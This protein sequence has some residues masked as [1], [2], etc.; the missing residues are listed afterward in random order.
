MNDPQE[1]LVS[2]HLAGLA[3]IDLWLDRVEQMAGLPKSIKDTCASIR[4]YVAHCRRAVGRGETTPSELAR[5]K[6]K[7]ELTSIAVWEFLQSRA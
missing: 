1:R 2:T 7:I 5:R 6:R 4:R 3:S